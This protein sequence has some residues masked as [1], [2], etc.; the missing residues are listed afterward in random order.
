MPRPK[1]ER[2]LTSAREKLLQAHHLGSTAFRPFPR[3]VIEDLC[4][5]HGLATDGTKANMIDRLFVFV[6][7]VPNKNHRVKLTMARS[8]LSK[9][10][11]SDKSVLPA[12]KPQGN[13]PSAH[14]GRH[15]MG[16]R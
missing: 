15:R 11:S 8:E 4:R 7:H 9:S 12:T 16:D 13:P 10:P 2:N 14:V 1:L 6:S 5:A 3:A